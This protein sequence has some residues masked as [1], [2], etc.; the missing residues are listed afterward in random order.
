M[1]K[2][3]NKPRKVDHIGIS[4]IIF[5]HT[6]WVSLWGFK[7]TAGRPEPMD[8]IINFERLN[9][10]LRL[11]GQ[12][13]DRIQ[14]L[15]VEKLEHG[16]EEPSIIDLEDEF[17]QPV[18]FNHCLLEVSPTWSENQSGQWEQD[19]QCLSIDAVY[20]LLE[21]RKR[22]LSRQTKYRQTLIACEDI[23]AESYALYLGYLEL[24]IEEETALQ[25]AGLEDDLKF[26]MAYYAWKMNQATA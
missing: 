3:D 11:S 4:R 8:Y 23:L 16:V 24:E 26:K 25:M 13:G 6:E 5:D 9:K 2:L 15:I 18:L 7:M 14:M 1:Q 10:L 19:R 22:T 17:G 21:K 20:P 12:E